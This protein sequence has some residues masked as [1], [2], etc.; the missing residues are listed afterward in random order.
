MSNRNRV[1]VQVLVDG[2][3]GEARAFQL[4]VGAWAKHSNNVRSQLYNDCSTAPCKSKLS[5]RQSEI[6]TPDQ[7]QPEFLVDQ[8][9]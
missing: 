9:F 2:D 6:V 5:S 4:R 7:W 8:L 1:P 3:V